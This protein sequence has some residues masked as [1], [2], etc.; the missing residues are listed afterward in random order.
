MFTLGV[1]C[2]SGFASLFPL[3]FA[4]IYWRRVTKAGAIASVV[5]TA[6]VCVCVRCGVC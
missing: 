4:A 6:V 3:V 1:W 2:F 5:V